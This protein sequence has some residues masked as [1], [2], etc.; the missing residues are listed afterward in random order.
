MPASVLILHENCHL[1]DGTIQALKGQFVMLE[2]V[3]VTERR[4][5]AQ[6]LSRLSDGAAAEQTSAVATSA[7]VMYAT[8]GK[9]S[10]NIT[11]VQSK[12][13]DIHCD[14]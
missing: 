11:P 9:D 2:D 8:D 10:P 13:T 12:S 5:K 7:P 1:T 14:V 3:L 4:Q 6:L